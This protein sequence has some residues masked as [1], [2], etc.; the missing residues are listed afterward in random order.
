[1]QG[2]TG[3]ALLSALYG[4]FDIVAGIAGLV[5]GANLTSRL[6]TNP[7]FVKF[8][9]RATKVPAGAVAAQINNLGKGVSDSDIALAVALLEDNP[10]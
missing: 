7:N 1:L 3:G 8:L 4:R 6:M 2:T 5:G 9:A 10:N